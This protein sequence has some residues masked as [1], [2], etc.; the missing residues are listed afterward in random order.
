M[1]ERVGNL[2]TDSADKFAIPLVGG[3]GAG[4]VVEYAIAVQIPE[5]FQRVWRWEDWVYDPPSGLI[6][7]ASDPD[8][9]IPL[10]E[11]LLDLDRQDKDG[12]FA[13]ME[14]N[15]RLQVEHTVTEAISGVDL[16]QTQI[17][18]AEGEN[19]QSLGLETPPQTRGSAIPD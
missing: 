3:P 2:E 12:A 13:F 5:S 9:L 6:V 19:L 14:A 15:P 8:Q 4:G 11:F 18:I 1:A 10:T 16:V 17:R 7:A